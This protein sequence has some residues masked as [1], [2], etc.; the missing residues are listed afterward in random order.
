M[1]EGKDAA[2]EMQQV[3]Q[4]REK[5]IGPEHPDTLESCYDFAFGLEH[6]GKIQE[7]E[8]FAKRAAEGARKVL[9]PDH[10]DTKKYEKLLHELE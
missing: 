5:A 3:I 8:E 1:A 4:L 10:P 2:A 7:A 9:G 6:Q